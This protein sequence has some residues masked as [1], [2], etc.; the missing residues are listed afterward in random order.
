MNVIKD[1]SGLKYTIKDRHLQACTRKGTRPDWGMF[2]RN[3]A[4][5]AGVSP[6]RIKTIVHC[7]RE[8]HTIATAAE[9][10]AFATLLDC[11]AD[12]LGDEAAERMVAP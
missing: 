7:K 4:I 10:A 3:A 11:T 12:V 9:L 1:R 2:Y 5:A 8:S 6:G